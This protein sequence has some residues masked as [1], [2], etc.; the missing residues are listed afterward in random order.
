MNRVGKA[1]Y[2]NALE[3]GILAVAGSIKICRLR[4]GDPEGYLSEDENRLEEMLEAVL[5]LKKLEGIPSKF[6]KVE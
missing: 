3:Q 4:G 1:I 6:T 2:L 5:Q